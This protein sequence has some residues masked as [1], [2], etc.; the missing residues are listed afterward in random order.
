MEHYAF[1][2]P[3]VL[4]ASA[5]CK[6]LNRANGTGASLCFD[7]FNI[8]GYPTLMYGWPGNWNSY[9]GSRQFVDLKNFVEA[10]KHEKEGLQGVGATRDVAALR[11]T[12]KV[13]GADEGQCLEEG[14]QGQ[15]P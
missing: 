1:D 10:H 14:S 4:I 3:N 9:T 11:G 7:Q 2:H 8:R 13:H 6:Q 15:N 12:G 5:E